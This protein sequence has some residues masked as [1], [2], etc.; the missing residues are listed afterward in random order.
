MPKSQGLTISKIIFSLGV[1]IPMYLW[2]LF[3]RDKVQLVLDLAGGIPGVFL[4][5]VFPPVFVYF[6][7]KIYNNEENIHKSNF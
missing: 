3:L 7:R 6:A 5:F 2:A 1:T 4:I